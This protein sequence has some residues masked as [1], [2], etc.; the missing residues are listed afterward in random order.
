M[1]RLAPLLLALVLAAPALAAERKP[2]R[3][4]PVPVS[5]APDP[6]ALLAELEARLGEGEKLATRLRQSLDQ[7]ATA[8]RALQDLRSDAFLAQDHAAL[9]QIIAKH[10]MAG[11]RTGLDDLAEA[12]R[13]PFWKRAELAIPTGLDKGYAKLV[14]TLARLDTA[15]KP[16]PKA[17]AETIPFK[18]VQ[19]LQAAAEAVLPPL[20]PLLVQTQSLA[21]S[22][23][24]AIPV[25][26]R[27]I[28]SL[29]LATG[30]TTAPRIAPP[31]VDLDAAKVREA[32]EKEEKARKEQQP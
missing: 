7:V 17:A 25:W 18:R 11:L 24:R 5:A 12:L 4:A 19:A 15:L 27:R 31:I 23:G 28:D 21:A 20:F 16:D 32:V 6:K 22:L 14:G 10:D 2:V 26:S 3:P 8:A 29:R 1:T 13:L 9:D 30:P